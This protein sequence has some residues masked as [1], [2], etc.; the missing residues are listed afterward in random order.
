MRTNLLSAYCPECGYRN[1][2]L[3]DRKFRKRIR[4]ES[5][6]VL[7]WQCESCGAEFESEVKWTRIRFED[8]VRFLALSVE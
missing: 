8:L 7:S 6:P 2:Y 1:S 5:W 4:T 3:T